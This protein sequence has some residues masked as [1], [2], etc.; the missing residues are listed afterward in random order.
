MRNIYWPPPI[1]SIAGGA[2]KKVSQPVYLQASSFGPVLHLTSHDVQ[3]VGCHT[4]Q[5]SGSPVH[6]RNHLE[7]QEPSDALHQL[8]DPR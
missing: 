7:P 5:E 6:G 4:G 8:V 2:A 1:T 3:G